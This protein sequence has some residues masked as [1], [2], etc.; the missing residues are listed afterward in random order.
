MRCLITGGAGFIG[1]HLSER[2]LRFG[3]EVIA[4]DDLST[5]TVENILSFRSHPSYEFHGDSIFNRRL[6][7]EL[8]DLADIVFHLAA[9]VGVKRI[10][11]YPVQTIETNVGGTEIVLELAAKRQRRLIIAST[12]EVYGK[13]NKLPFSEVDDLVLG[14]TYN[15]RWAYACSKA[16]DEFLALA[17]FRERKL[18]VSIV[19]LFNTV[20][21]RQTGQYGMVVPTFVRQ[22]LLGQP[23]T[24]FGDGTQSRCFGHVSDVLDGLLAVAADDSTAGEIFNLG[25]TEEITIRELADRVIAITG[26]SSPIRYVPYTEAY[27]PG[28]EDMNRRI[29]DISKAERWLGYRPKYGLDD[30]LQDVVAFVREQIDRKKAVFLGAAAK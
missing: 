22:A 7:A 14:S 19:R 1:S 24:V 20:G 5:S 27:A 18:P 17:Y 2:L 21:P 25:N 3:H 16:I 8:V 12:S 6:M 23:I 11:D 28:F 4:I 9:A 13:S 10:V 26:S 15:Q 29:P 30:I